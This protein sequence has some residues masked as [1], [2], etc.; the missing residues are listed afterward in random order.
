MTEVNNNETKQETCKCFCQSERFKDFLTKT[1]AVFIGVFAALSL[2]AVLPQAATQNT[3]ATAVIS[4]RIFFI[5]FV[6]FLI[7]F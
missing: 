7:K 4:A 6:P 3:I 2:F 1:L 5:V